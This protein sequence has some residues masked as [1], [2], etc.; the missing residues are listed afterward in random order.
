[1]LSWFCSIFQKINIFLT[2]TVIHFSFCD[3]F[4]SLSI[5]AIVTF[6]HIGAKSVFSLRLCNVGI[7]NLIF[8]KY[9]QLLHLKRRP[10]LQRKWSYCLDL[11]SVMISP[12]QA[13][14]PSRHWPRNSI[15]LEHWLLGNLM[16]MN[17]LTIIL[18]LIS[19]EYWQLIRT[20]TITGQTDRQTQTPSLENQW[21][22]GDQEKCFRFSHESLGANGTT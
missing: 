9:S 8:S 18:L 16:K 19:I 11:T 5:Y 1:M 7:Y 10:Q 20:K 15:L 3:K 14:K 13:W 21:G 4:L 17:V 22:D 2:G 6:Q 12:R